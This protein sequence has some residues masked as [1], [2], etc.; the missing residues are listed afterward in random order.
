MRI[1]GTTRKVGAGNG[2]F[3]MRFAVASEKVAANEELAA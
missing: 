1:E 2:R 3:A